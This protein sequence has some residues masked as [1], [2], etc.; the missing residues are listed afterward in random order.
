MVCDVVV[1][2]GERQF[3]HG[4]LKPNMTSGY[5]GSMRIGREATV[6]WRPSPTGNDINRKVRLDRNPGRRWEVVFDLD[7][8]SVKARCQQP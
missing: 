4:N 8:E 3:E 5:S 7:G 1:R 2:S 6:S